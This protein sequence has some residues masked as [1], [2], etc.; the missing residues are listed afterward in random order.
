MILQSRDGE[1]I[2]GHLAH[3]LLRSVLIIRSI[4]E[5][6]GMRVHH[7]EVGSSVV[8]T[9]LSRVVPVS[10]VFREVLFYL[11]VRSQGSVFEKSRSNAPQNS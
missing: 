11:G 9:K 6:E 4:V 1:R 3:S 2:A 7:P 5:S 8:I 10:F